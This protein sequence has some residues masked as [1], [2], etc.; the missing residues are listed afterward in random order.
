MEP[1][2]DIYESEDELLLIADL[3]GVPAEGL[4]L[5]LDRMNLTIQ[6]SILENEGKEQ[7]TASDGRA[8]DYRRTFILPLGIDP[9]KI[10]A[11]LAD[12]V[13]RVHMPKAAA[14]PPRQIQIEKG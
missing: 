9:D 10:R 13:L 1:A 8:T 6:G 7:A 4:R 14:R 3:P 2:V 11:E 12:G 5:A